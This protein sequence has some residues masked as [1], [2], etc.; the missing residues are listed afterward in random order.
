M[1]AVSE[2]TRGVEVSNIFFGG[3]LVVIVAVLDLFEVAV[4][5]SDWLALKDDC[6]MSRIDPKSM[7]TGFS[8]LLSS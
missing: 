6:C 4:D 2:G 8:V 5:A 7:V 3:A 1:L